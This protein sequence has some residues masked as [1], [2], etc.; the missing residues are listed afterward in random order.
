MNPLLQ[1]PNNR[2][3]PYNCWTAHPAQMEV[4][5]HSLDAM[6]EDGFNKVAGLASSPPTPSS[7]V[8]V[9]RPTV[10]VFDALVEDSVGSLSLDKENNKD[11]ANTDG[12]NILQYATPTNP[13]DLDVLPTVTS[14]S[15][16]ASQQTLPES[17]DTSIGIPATQPVRVPPVVEPVAATLGAAVAGAIGMTVEEVISATDKL[18]DFTLDLTRRE[19][20]PMFSPPDPD[21]AGDV[22]EPKCIQGT[23]GIFLVAP[24]AGSGK[25]IRSLTC[26]TQKHLGRSP[27]WS[28]FG[29]RT[30]HGQG[31]IRAH[32]GANKHCMFSC[33]LDFLKN[34]DVELKE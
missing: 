14:T 17:L 28:W 30:P 25:C 11:L 33:I 13:M 26:A 32:I 18:H 8:V 23:D 5:T 22:I 24:F 10:P 19:V 2:H 34:F 21:G 29:E 6:L 7:P 20:P 31:R 15:A 27:D 9:S 1:S 4:N 3:H 16:P 12:Y